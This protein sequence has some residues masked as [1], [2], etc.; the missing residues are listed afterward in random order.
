MAS[1]A[2]DEDNTLSLHIDAAQGRGRCIIDTVGRLSQLFPGVRKVFNRP[3]H[4]AFV[5]VSKFRAV[6]EQ[7]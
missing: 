4:D 3:V 7:D 2:S 5:C 6:G 1:L